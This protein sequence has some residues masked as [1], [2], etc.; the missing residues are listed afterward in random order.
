L[1]QDPAVGVDRI[2]ETRDDTGAGIVA[3]DS[4]LLAKPVGIGNIVRVHPR[5]ERRSR[6]L[7]DHVRAGDG[8]EL[9]VGFEQPDPGIQSRKLAKLLPRAVARRIVE[10]HE[11]EIGE[12]LAKDAVDSRVEMR[13]CVV[14]RHHDAQARCFGTC[15]RPWRLARTHP[16]RLKQDSSMP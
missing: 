13:E 12:A 15:S 8:S 7:G 11:L 1:A 16:R 2:A 10:D 4:K 14:H 9:L 6:G 5:D 3:Q